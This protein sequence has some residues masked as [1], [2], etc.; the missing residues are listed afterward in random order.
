M[1]QINM[2]TL[3]ISFASL[4]LSLVIAYFSYFR[5]A[6]IRLLAGRN[7]TFFPSKVKTATGDIV[8]ITFNIPITFYNWSPQGGTVYKIR[9]AIGRQQQGEYYDMTWTTFVKI[10][11]GGSFEDESL[12]QPI[13]LAG[14]SS[15]NKIIRFDWNPEFTGEKFDVQVGKY[16]LMIFGWTKNTEKPDLKYVTSFLFKDDHYKKYENS[17]SNSSLPIW[18]SVEDNERANTIIT[19]ARIDSFYLRK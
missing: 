10:G 1:Q 11:S 7:I 13:P 14:K 19:K 18:L 12:A 9:L 8:G 17:L 5:F 4:L 2:P 15:I 16:D 3:L 6:E